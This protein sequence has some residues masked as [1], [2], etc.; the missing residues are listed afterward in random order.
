ME[1]KGLKRVNPD[2]VRAQL[3]NLKPGEDVT[4]AE[5]IEDTSRIYA[6][7]DF[8]QVSYRL[9]GPTE[10]RTLEITPVE[11]SWGPN[12]VRFDLGLAAN[13]DGSLDALGRVDY[14]RTWL[15]SLGAEWHNAL[16]LGVQTLAETDF[17]QPIDVAQR[18]FIQPTAMY[19]RDLEDIY[20]DGDRIAT[21]LI[22]QLFAEIDAGVNLGTRA[23]VRVG[24]RSGWYKAEV[25]TGP[26]VLP[27]SPKETD[28]SVQL[29]VVYDTR[30]SVAMPTSGTFL[31]A[32]LV[33]SGAWLGGEQDYGLA[34]GVIAKAFPFR[35]DALNLILGGGKE[36]HGRCPHRGVPAWRR[37]DVPRAAAR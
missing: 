16:Q 13:G 30:N 28:T 9:I 33:S 31:N 23:Q 25:D 12:F 18:Y 6:L 10:S 29:R 2:Y 11:K 34:E 37:P 27:T 21:Y 20:N 3:H 7:G 5:I 1:V 35:G 32:R 4:P 15:N 14:N 26:T 22:S 36:L 19:E 8:E 17:Y 24:L